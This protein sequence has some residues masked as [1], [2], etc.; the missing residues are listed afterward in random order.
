MI[1]METRETCILI[2]KLNSIVHIDQLKK[3]GSGFRRGMYFAETISEKKVTVA[4]KPNWA[5]TRA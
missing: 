3:R 1:I 2:P 5:R 4:R